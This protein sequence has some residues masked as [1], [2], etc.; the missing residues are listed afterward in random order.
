MRAVAVPQ[1]TAAVHSASAVYRGAV[2]RWSPRLGRRQPASGSGR[3][4][5]TDPT[6]SG[7]HRVRRPAVADQRGPRRTVSS[8]ARSD[9]GLT[10]PRRRCVPSCP[11]ACAHR[12]HCCDRHAVPIAV[13]AAVDRLRRG[14]HDDWPAGVDRRR[15]DA[16]DRC[17][18]PARRD[19]GVTVVTVA[20]DATTSP[21]VTVATTATALP[22]TSHRGGGSHE[23]DAVDDAGRHCRHG[24][25]E[26]RRHGTRGHRRRQCQASTID[27]RRGPRHDDDDRRSSAWSGPR[28]ATTTSRR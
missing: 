11:P 3:S 17:R 4:T 23:R 20:S 8:P 21:P 22:T 9:R 15:A 19:H 10:Q 18:P 25:R 1:R 12:H 6:K 5:T 2:R 7:A 13:V 27:Y 24:T 26:H 16:A 28:R 14:G